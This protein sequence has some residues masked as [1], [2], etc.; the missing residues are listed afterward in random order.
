MYN[1]V[2]LVT[3]DIPLVRHQL[4]NDKDR[5]PVNVLFLNSLPES[6]KEGYVLQFLKH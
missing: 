3:N 6:N 1:F 4:D 5:I 2:D